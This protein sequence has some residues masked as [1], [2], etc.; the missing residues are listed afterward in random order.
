MFDGATFKS[1]VACGAT[2][3]PAALILHPLAAGL[4]T[5]SLQPMGAA[6]SAVRLGVP[7]PTTF[8][9][10]DLPHVLDPWATNGVEAFSARIIVS[11]HSA[12]GC[13]VAFTHGSRHRSPSL[14][15]E[16]GTHTDR[17]A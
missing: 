5:V 1:G 17:R 8:L 2:G 6:T 13:I 14:T 10:A 12:S 4:T 7:A 9:G 11:S 15:V 3:T 16:A